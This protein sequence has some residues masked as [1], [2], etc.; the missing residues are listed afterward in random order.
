MNSLHE[1]RQEAD[2]AVQKIWFIQSL[3]EVERTDITLS[4]RL[5]IRHGLFVQL[6]A[7]LNSGS[8]YMALIEGGQRLFGIDR[9]GSKWHMHPFAAVEQHEPMIEALEPKPIL[10]FLARVEHLLLEHDLL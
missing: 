7:G 9:E 1:L 6:F 4:L 10:K 8:L 5:T 3:E 2:E